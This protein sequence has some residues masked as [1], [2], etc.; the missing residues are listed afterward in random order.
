MADTL[1]IDRYPQ[2]SLLAWN[3]AIRDIEGDEAF[4][5]YEGNWRFVDVNELTEVEV[6]LI[7]RLTQQYGNGVLNV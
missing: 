1:N 4:A 3:R 7:N 5:L 2:L 6:N